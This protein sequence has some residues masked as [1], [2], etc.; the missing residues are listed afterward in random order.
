MKGW[1]F[2]VGIEGGDQDRTCNAR[3]WDMHTNTYLLY[4]VKF[5]MVL[6]STIFGKPEIYWTALEA[7]GT[8]TAVIVALL[9]GLYAVYKDRIVP[10]LTAS[11]CK[12]EFFT[13]CEGSR[14]ERGE[15]IVYSVPPKIKTS[16]KLEN[17][18]RRFIFLKMDA[19]NVI[20][21][22]WLQKEPDEHGWI[23]SGKIDAFPY[24]PFGKDFPQHANENR[25][26]LD[27]GKYLLSLSFSIDNKTVG[28]HREIIEYPHTK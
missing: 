8:L 11:E 25:D 27:E 13:G 19:S 26:S 10:N 6:L 22:W 21:N 15:T 14:N 23:Y 3:I 24:I 18:Q 5:I 4:Q 12:I 20:T 9:L 2:S 7:I 28:N 17:K 16:W 1:G